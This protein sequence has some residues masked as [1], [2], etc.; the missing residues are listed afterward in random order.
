VAS[1]A[2]IF[3]KTDIKDEEVKASEVV[4]IVVFGDECEKMG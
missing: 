2:A 1:T 4:K 3:G